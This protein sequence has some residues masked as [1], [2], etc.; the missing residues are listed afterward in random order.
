MTLTMSS[1]VPVQFGRRNCIGRHVAYSTLWITIASILRVY[2]MD[3]VCRSVSQRML[4]L[5]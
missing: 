2:N 4:W 3:K 5:C 1:S